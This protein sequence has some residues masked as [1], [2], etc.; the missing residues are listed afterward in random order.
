MAALFLYSPYLSAERHAMR[1]DSLSKPL[2]ERL[3]ECLQT[4]HHV[5][6]WVHSAILLTR[7]YGCQ[8]Q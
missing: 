4:L 7:Q 3:S 1:A 5:L 2:T 6:S 8:T